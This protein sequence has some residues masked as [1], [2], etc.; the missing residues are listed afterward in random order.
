MLLGLKLKRAY[1]F[2]VNS[3][4]ECGRLHTRSGGP[5]KAGHTNGKGSKLNSLPLVSRMEV[6]LKFAKFCLVGGSGVLVDMG[7]LYLMADPTCLGINLTLSKIVA[8][9]TA[10]TNNFIWNDLWTFRRTS[11]SPYSPSSEESRPQSGVFRRFIVFNTICGVGIGL[12]VLLLHLF[13]TCLALNLYVANLLSIILV[14]IWNY[15]M[16]VRWNWGIGK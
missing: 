11:H 2:V 12:S 9:E 14:A 5:I 16:N 6:V 8:A 13:H 4:G 3:K 7:V 10:M 1:E 15:G